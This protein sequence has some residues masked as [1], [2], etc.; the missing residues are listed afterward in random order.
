[1][2][3]KL[4]KLQ[5]KVCLFLPPLQQNSV[6]NK[7]LKESSREPARETG[8]KGGGWEKEEGLVTC[9]VLNRVIFLVSFETEDKGLD[10]I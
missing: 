4:K 7:S 6:K 10:F 3:E 9:G 1:M 2:L 5:I 8:T